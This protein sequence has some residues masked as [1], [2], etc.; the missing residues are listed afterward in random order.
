MDYQKLYLEQKIQT[1]EM[2]L[3]AIQMRF[4]MIQ[5]E[6]PQVRKEWAEYLEKIKDKT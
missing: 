5:T 2:E 1:L 3:S 6:L 4:G